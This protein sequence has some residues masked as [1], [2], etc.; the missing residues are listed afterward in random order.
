MQASPK[1]E[2]VWL[3]WLLCFFPSWFFSC[4]LLSALH[5]EG[6]AR[7]LIFTDWSDMKRISLTT[8]TRLTRRVLWFMKLILF[9]LR[10]KMIIDKLIAVLLWKARCKLT[11]LCLV[12]IFIIL[13]SMG[14]CLSFIVL[15]VRVSVGPNQRELL[16]ATDN[17]NPALPDT[18]GSVTYVYHYLTR[19]IKIYLY[20]YN[21]L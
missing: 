11:S 6:N 5:G 19:V 20:F 2:N 15:C 3:S 7:Q 16:S 12:N 8:K 13:C 21:L 9:S 14:N 10:T 17:T 4:P 1:V 18:S